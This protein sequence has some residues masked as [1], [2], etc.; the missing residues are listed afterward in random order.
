MAGIHVR[1]GDKV[2]GSNKEAEFMPVSKYMSK[3]ER[4]FK[5]LEEMSG[6]AIARRLFVATDQVTKV[7][8]T[9]LR[10]FKMTGSKIFL[11]SSEPAYL[12]V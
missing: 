2:W 5:N 4:Y 11:I 3:V 10:Q 6:E 9:I 12:L 8:S 1:R 7:P